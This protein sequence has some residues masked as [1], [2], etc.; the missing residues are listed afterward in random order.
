MTYKVTIVWYDETIEIEADSE[1]EARN[2]VLHSDATR[3]L[4]CDELYAERSNEDE[5]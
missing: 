4:Y 2:L 1:E 5:V 3:R